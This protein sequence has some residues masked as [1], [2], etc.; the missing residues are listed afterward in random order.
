[1]LSSTFRPCPLY[2][3]GYIL[4]EILSLFYT[5]ILPSIS[6]SPVQ[7]IT[8]LG[9]GLC[10]VRENNA[11]VSV[12]VNYIL[13]IAYPNPIKQGQKC[14]TIL[15]SILFQRWSSWTAFL[16]E[17][18]DH[19]LESSQTRVIVWFFTLIFRFYKMLFKNILKFLV[20]WIILYGLLIPE[21]KMAFL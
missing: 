1:M 3:F 4:L 5:T 18:S 7:Y 16:V 13:A 10:S 9:K 12:R 17:V 14:C 11:I 21:N 2:F 6:F 19:K 8:S 20:S 15:L